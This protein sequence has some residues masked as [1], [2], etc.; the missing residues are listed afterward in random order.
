[1]SRP[2]ASLPNT[3]A[4]G[5]PSMSANDPFNKV[6]Q[7]GSISETPWLSASW[8]GIND[9]IFMSAEEP[10]E[11]TTNVRENYNPADH[12]IVTLRRMTTASGGKPLFNKEDALTPDA[13]AT[14]DQFVKTLG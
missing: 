7:V 4:I 14:L 6:D 3:L 5:V 2:Q 10:R 1:M 8:T 11:L 12:R 13:N 9:E